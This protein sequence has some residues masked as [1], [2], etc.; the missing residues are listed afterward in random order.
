MIEDWKYQL[1]V[2]FK[3]GGESADGLGLLDALEEKL[4]EIDDE[5]A[6]F[7]GHDIGSGEVNFFIMTNE[8][9]GTFARLRLLLEGDG[10]LNRSEIAYRELDGEEF[11]AL[12]PPGLKRFEVT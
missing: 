9:N 12:W 7:D 2:Q 5:R 11:T 10:L 1:V 4:E 8:P 6:L 3:I